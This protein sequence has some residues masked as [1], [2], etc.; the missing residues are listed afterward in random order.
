[1]KALA[2]IDIGDNTCD[3]L[4]IEYKIGDLE[5]EMIIQTGVEKLKP[6]P[7]KRE[8]EWTDSFGKHNFKKG[9]NVCIDE[10]LGENNEVN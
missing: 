1:M 5:T 10:I 3:G 8:I 6:M 4:I 7:K 9:F 2:I